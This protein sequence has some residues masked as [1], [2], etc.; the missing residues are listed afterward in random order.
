MLELDGR[1]A[2]FQL[3]KALPQDE[4]EDRVRLEDVFVRPIASNTEFARP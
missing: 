3:E 1:R 2:V 4:G